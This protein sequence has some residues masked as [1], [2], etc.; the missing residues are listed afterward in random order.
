MFMYI[1]KLLEFSSSQFLED[2]I[3]KVP[4]IWE[5]LSDTFINEKNNT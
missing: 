3:L 4:Q 1:Y 5:I 2:S